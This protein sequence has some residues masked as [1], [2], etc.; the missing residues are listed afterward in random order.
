M[1][2]DNRAIRVLGKGLTALAVKDKFPNAILY[3]DKDFSLYDL[4]S[5]EITVVSPGIPPYYE[6]IGKSKNL[7]SDYD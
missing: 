3:D 2:I 7:Q 5:D 4:E 6:M 1:K